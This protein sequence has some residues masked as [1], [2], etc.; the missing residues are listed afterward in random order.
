MDTALAVQAA[1]MT[2]GVQIPKPT[3]MLDGSGSLLVIP[4]LRGQRQR[5]PPNKLVSWASGNHS[6]WV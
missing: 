2:N 3:E 5:I 4:A 6:L 1:G